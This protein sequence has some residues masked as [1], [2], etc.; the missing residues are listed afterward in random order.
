VVELFDVV[1]VFECT[2]FLCF[3]VYVSLHS[4]VRNVVVISYYV[5]LV[6]SSVL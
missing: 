2:C 3:S 1:M 5:S 6:L 4:D